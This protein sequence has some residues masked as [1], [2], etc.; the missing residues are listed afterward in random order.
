M[1]GCSRWISS[2]KSTSPFSRLV[3]SPAS[4]PAFSIT[5][6][7]VFLMFTAMALAMICASVVLPK[8]G[9]PLSRICSSTSPRFRAASTNSS[10]RSQTFTWPVNSLNI[11]GRSD[12][13]KAGSGS[14]GFIISSVQIFRQHQ[15][16]ST[17]FQNVIDFVE[18]VLDQV[19]PETAR[20]DQIVR[21]IFD[22]KGWRLFPV[23]AQSHPHTAVQSLEGKRDELIVAEVIGVPNN[24]G[25]SFIDT[26]YHQGAFPV[27]KRVGLEKTAHEIA[28]QSQIGGVAGEL[29]LFFH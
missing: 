21:P 28:H 29:D 12:I 11:G 23:I 18:R 27:G 6:P 19:Q 25:A 13:S 9:G 4:S 3:R 16:S 24:V 17:A 15:F 22:G 20:F 14:G 10:S 26:E 7:L 5:G 2:I 8:P 1:V